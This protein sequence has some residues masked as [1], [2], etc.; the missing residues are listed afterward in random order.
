MERVKARDLKVGMFVSL[1]GG[2]LHHSFLVGRFRIKSE[3]QIGKIIAAGF[4]DVEV[5]FE[6]SDSNHSFNGPEEEVVAQQEAEA[7][8]EPAKPISLEEFVEVENTIDDIASSSRTPVRKAQAVYHHSLQMVK[9]LF[10]NPSASFIGS[11]KR[12][13]GKVVDIIL[14]D[15][16]TADCLLKVSSHD[17][18]TYM[19]SM[20]VGVYATA[21]AKKIYR[22][23]SGHN[24]REAGA[25]FFL[26]DLGKITTPQS[27][28]N[29]PGRL[30]PEEMEVMRKHPEESYNILRDT[31]QLSDECSVIAL[32][33]HEREDGTGYPFG[34]KGDQIHDYA[35]ICSIADVF[36]ALTSKRSYR[37]PSTAFEAMG[38]MRDEMLGHFH[39]EMLRDFIMLFRG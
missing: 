30:T 32:Q 9:Q 19:H 27:I 1:P 17:E 12:V 11:S 16:E 38:I 39:K 14:T 2:W 34:L 15:D 21:L 23:Q 35:R 4:T 6:K 37:E 22:G 5:D 28:I 3:S 10:E 24:L 25:G 20:N 36:D 33:H 13:V 26:H 31:D 29:K 7:V 8:A 18:Y